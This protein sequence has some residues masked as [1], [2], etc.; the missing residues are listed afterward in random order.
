MEEV[1]R[2]FNNYEVSTTGIV[3]NPRTGRILK[4]GKDTS[5]Y[6]Q[7]VLFIN[8]SS[9]NYKVHRIVAEVFIPNPNNYPEVN[10]KDENKLNN[11]VDNL[12]W[13]PREYNVNYGTRNEKVSKSMTNGK[14]SKT[15]YQYTLDGQLVRMW[16]STMEC[17]R[18][19]FSFGCVAACCRGQ[20]SNHKGFRWS[21]N[22]P[23]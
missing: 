1:W 13:C 23:A 11:R 12:E 14:L 20:R 17:G 8:G 7:V 18:N 3:R 4:P 2:P 9:K 5:G 15:V 6:M 10:H 21:Y 22:P 19:G 16:P